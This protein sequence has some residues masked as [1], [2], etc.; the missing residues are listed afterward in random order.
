MQQCDLTMATNKGPS[1]SNGADGT[2]RG[3]EHSC[4][5]VKDVTLRIIVKW[6]PTKYDELLADIKLWN[7]TETDMV[8]YI[9]VT[10]TGAVIYPWET[11]PGAV[12]AIPFI[13]LTPDNL[14]NYLGLQRLP[15]SSVYL[16]F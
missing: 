4:V 3:T 14:P 2:K 5:K 15:F 9:P 12:P 13:D 8:H 7:Y 6:R 10:A 11:A 1:I 16:Q